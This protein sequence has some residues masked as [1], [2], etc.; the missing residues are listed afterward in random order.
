LCTPEMWASPH[1][2]E[3]VRAAAD[4]ATPCHLVA[5]ALMGAL[6][7]TVTPQG[8]LAVAEMPEVTLELTRAVDMV[9]VLDRLGDPGNVGTILRT[10]QATGVGA[11]LLSKGCADAYAPKV[12]RA[13]MGAHSRLPI[14]HDRSWA[15]IGR[16]LAGKACVAADPRGGN[17]P[18][19]L[20]WTRPTAL[21][22]GSEAQG[23]GAEA[24]AL[25]QERVSLPMRAGVESLNV[26]VATAV[27]LFEALRQREQ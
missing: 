25:A 15:D 6:G 27:L 20:D 12:V 2:D 17:R 16:A 19:A 13:A 10:A 1:G 5:P 24:G 26:A 9:L 23:V 22:V 21:I 4:R 11:V 14:F 3:L 18:W 7:D 8:V